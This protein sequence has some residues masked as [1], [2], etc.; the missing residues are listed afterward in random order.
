MRVLCGLLM[1]CALAC[2]TAGAEPS[3]EAWFFAD[4]PH[5]R[6]IMLHD[7]MNPWDLHAVLYAVTSTA[8]LE[9]LLLA[10]GLLDAVTPG[11]PRRPLRAGVR[12]LRRAYARLPRWMLTRRV[13]ELVDAFQLP[14]LSLGDATSTY[15]FATGGTTGPGSGTVVR[16]HKLVDWL[17]HVVG[18][19]NRLAGRPLRRPD[20]LLSW[21]GPER[22]VDGLQTIVTRTFN[23]VSLFAVRLLD[24]G[25]RGVETAG[26]AGLRRVV[27]AAHQD[28]T[29]FLRMPLGVYWTHEAW[30]LEHRRQVVIGTA[31]EFQAGTHATLAHDPREQA[32]A[33]WTPVRF[34]AETSQSVIVMTTSRLLARAPAPLKA[35]VVPAAW[36][37][38]PI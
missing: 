29:V 4:C 11:R 8:E 17:Q 3:G 31:A 35:Y 23:V 1:A 18:D 22:G 7:E 14:E 2:P 32:L 34:S 25:L 36:I 5:G 20:G 33:D 6:V 37:L 19:V 10:D 27:P 9:V 24:D 21:R 16:V 38:E 28:T 26:E 12:T 30:V 15:A 13:G